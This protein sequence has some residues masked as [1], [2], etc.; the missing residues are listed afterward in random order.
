MGLSVI[1]GAK[2]RS[3][4]ITGTTNEY[5]QSG[6]WELAS[7]RL[8][9]DSEV[10]AGAPVCVI[11]ETTRKELFG[12]QEP[13]GERIRL[14]SVAC[15]II[16]LLQSKGKSTFGQD[17]DDTVVIPLR[18]LQRRL[19]GDDDIHQIQ[20]SVRASTSS[21]KAQQDI[22]RLMRER[23]R[24]AKDADDD[25][26]GVDESSQDQARRGRAD[27]YLWHRP[28]AVERH[29]HRGRR[30]LRHPRQ[31]PVGRGRAPR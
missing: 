27:L 20:L 6:N 24:L 21:E 28:E 31:G 23:R 22:F 5:F 1:S 2:N 4:T 10:R 16:G 12:S 7:G 19:S 9:Y 25:I 14:R 8:F 18:T 29:P 26:A 15:T 11:G 17:R 30:Q 13:I 3:T